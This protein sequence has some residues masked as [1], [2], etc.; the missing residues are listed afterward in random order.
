VATLSLK[1]DATR[2]NVSHFS[3]KDIPFQVTSPEAIFNISFDV[4]ALDDIG[5]TLL[6]AAAPYGNQRQL[7]VLLALP[8]IRINAQ[9]DSGRTALMHALMKDHDNVVKLLLR[10]K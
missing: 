5:L 4:N 10:Q 7:T 8:D 2:H 1:E 3:S 9:G 6:M